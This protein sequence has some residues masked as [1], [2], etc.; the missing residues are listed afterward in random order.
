MRLC[1]EITR[2]KENKRHKRNAVMYLNLLVFILH[3]K[4]EVHFRQLQRNFYSFLNPAE[5][6]ALT[7]T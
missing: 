6:R 2:E 7:T 4:E 1:S 5:M 3:Y